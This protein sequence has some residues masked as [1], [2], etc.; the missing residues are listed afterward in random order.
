MAADG[1][2][3]GHIVSGHIDGIGSIRTIKKD[4]NAYIYTIA[5]EPEIT[6]YI[7]KKGSIAIDGISLTVTHVD[8]GSFSVS[9]IPHTLQ[10]TI[11]SDRKISD[12]VNL[13]VDM[14]AKYI[15]KLLL[16][17]VNPSTPKN[18]VTAEFLAKHG[19]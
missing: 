5:T 17:N 4:D 8:N 15:E 6:K 9:I 14:L 1:R 10:E 12:M 3:G 11:L 16:G 7:V 2:F 13:E 18:M 19:F